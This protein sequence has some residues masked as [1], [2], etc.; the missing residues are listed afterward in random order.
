MKQNSK[1]LIQ[2]LGD[3]KFGSA[4]KKAALYTAIPFALATGYSQKADAQ[5]IDFTT[6]GKKGGISTLPA[7]VEHGTPYL[8]QNVNTSNDN[9]LGIEKYP[10]DKLKG[11]SPS[12]IYEPYEMEGNKLIFTNNGVLGNK[13][14][15]DE[16]SYNIKDAEDVMGGQIDVKVK[17]FS[18]LFKTLVIKG[19]DGY[20]DTIYYPHYPQGTGEK[21]NS[22][23]FYKDDMLEFGVTDDGNNYY[24]LLD[25]KGDFYGWQIDKDRST[26]SGD[27]IVNPNYPKG[28]KDQLKDKIN[29]GEV[30]KIITSEEEKEPSYAVLR[31]TRVSPS[32][33]RGNGPNVRLEL[34]LAGNIHDF[35]NLE[36]NSADAIA[37]LGIGDNK[38]NFHV[39]PMAWYNF[40]N[41]G[42]KDV[43]R[44]ND[45]SLEEISNSTTDL[46][47]GVTRTKQGL[48]EVEKDKVIETINNY[49]WGAGLQFDFKLAK[50]L[51]LKLAGG[52]AE[53]KF[54]QETTE[55]KTETGYDVVTVQ[56]DGNVLFNDTLTNTSHHTNTDI[57]K[58]VVDFKSGK[59]FFGDIS[60]DFYPTKELAISLGGRLID[61]KFY[62]NL[63]FGVSINNKE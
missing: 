13:P 27:G 23:W 24:V 53:K 41:S 56:R 22:V 54:Q 5:D 50:G 46:G 51:E 6:S 45:Y 59:L 7:I 15:D 14:E 55:N 26:G 9:P 43:E 36:K 10:V 21:Q 29:T 17:D 63:K 20:N 31:D 32:R 33:R 11:K 30:E 40:T 34:A 42:I 44:T 37:Y 49:L 8:Y 3:S 28:Y 18:N 60:L 62:P 61:N 25:K 12:V 48:V 16:P 35:E 57:E 4:M 2:K 19:N 47:Y 39:G 52:L 38:G 1:N 58:Y